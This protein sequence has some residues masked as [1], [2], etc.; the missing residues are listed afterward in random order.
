MTISRPEPHTDDERDELLIESSLKGMMRRTEW[1]FWNDTKRNEMTML[2]K[3]EIF[4]LGT[5][6]T[7]AF[8]HLRGVYNSNPDDP[9]IHLAVAPHINKR[10]REAV[11]RGRGQERRR[12]ERYDNGIGVMLLCSFILLPL[13][14][15]LNLTLF[16]VLFR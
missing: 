4:A 5:V 7:L 9:P 16:A 3:G 11:S 2:T 6:A 8:Q 12:V 15:M 1:G 13:S 10:Y 14:V